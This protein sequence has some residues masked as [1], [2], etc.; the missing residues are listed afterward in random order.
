MCGRCASKK[1]AHLPQ[2]ANDCP[3]GEPPPAVLKLFNKRSQS[4]VIIQCDS[5]ITLFHLRNSRFFVLSFIYP[6]LVVDFTRCSKHN[7]IPP[8]ALQL[9]KLQ[10][11]PPLQVQGPVKGSTFPYYPRG[12]S[13]KPFLL[14][15]RLSY[16]SSIDK[17]TIVC[18]C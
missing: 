5:K 1:L 15:D 11:S 2:N 3:S 17:I 7:T 9:L 14:K 18:R 12:S 13:N 6:T 4:A 10:L 8:P 16:Y